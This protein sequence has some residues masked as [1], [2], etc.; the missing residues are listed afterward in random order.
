VEI[1]SP[2][3]LV[4]FVLSQNLPTENNRQIGENSPNLV[5]LVAGP[6]EWIGCLKTFRYAAKNNFKKVD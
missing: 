5:T 3:F 6:V 4:T 1:R 2:K